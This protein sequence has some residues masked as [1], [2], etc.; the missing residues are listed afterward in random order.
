MFVSWT[1]KDNESNRSGIPA[2]NL[3]KQISLS[4]AITLISRHGQNVMKNER[5]RKRQLLRRSLSHRAY[6]NYEDLRS[7][8]FGAVG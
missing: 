7:S 6:S 8:R 5:Q 3:A 1:W 2:K 4:V